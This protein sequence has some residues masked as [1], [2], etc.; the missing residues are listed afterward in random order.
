MNT[1]NRLAQMGF[2]LSLCAVAG[3]F[4]VGHSEA[5]GILAF[6]AIPSAIFSAFGLM[7]PPRRLAGWG[8]GI[9]LLVCLYLPTIL[10]SVI[11]AWKK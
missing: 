8:F 9:S 2:Y 5:G 1:A 7:A 4:L 10:T 3:L 11:F 6:L